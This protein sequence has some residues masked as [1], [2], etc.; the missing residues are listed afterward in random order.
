M[1]VSTVHKLDKIVFPSA[2]EI[3]TPRGL[4]ISH[5]IQSRL[6]WPAGHPHPMFRSTD[7]QKPE[8]GFN[9]PEI[10]VILGAI[11]VA[12]TSFTG[13]I[14]VYKKL[15]TV[16]GSVARATTSH[17]RLRI[18]ACLGYWTEIRLSHN[19]P[20]QIDVVLCATY[21]GSN[22][23]IAYAGTVALSGNLAAGT[24]FGAGPV[25]FNGA[26]IPGVKEITISS[27]I[28]LIREGAS[29]EVWDTFVGIERT[30]PSATIRALENVNWAT[31]GLQGVAMN[32]S[33]G[34]V[35]YGRKFIN[36]PNGVARVP[37]ATAQHIKLTAL[38]GAAIPVD[39]SADGSGLFV[40][41]IHFDL[42]AVSDSTLPV[43]A[44]TA[45]IIS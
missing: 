9:T 34:L 40:D 45:S 10:D 2:V 13:N 6:E 18:A 44:D 15:G 26:A 41:T 7:E 22:D 1:P 32:G 33:T 4:R 36:G 38:N 30:Q 19:Q 14:D 16:V 21:D 24:Y 25:S 12:G 31:L 11:T 39:G 8:V 37:D 3:S 29:S 23:P 28:S 17:K 43:V 5:G 20:G 42:I 27:G 35:M